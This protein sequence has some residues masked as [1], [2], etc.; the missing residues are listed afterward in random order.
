MCKIGILFLSI[1]FVGC[2]YQNSSESH[3]NVFEGN[4]RGGLADKQLSLTFDDGP[5]A[6]TSGVLDTLAKYNIKATFFVNGNNATRYENLLKRMKSEGHLV[7]NHTY[8][9]PSLPKQSESEIISQIT[10][11]HEAI[12]PY[13]DN[14]A[15]FFRA[16]FG[17]WATWIAN[18]LN[19]AGFDFYVGN[20]FWDIG[21]VLTENYAADWNCWSKSLS[22][23]E[24]G[25]RYIN[26]IKDRRSGI[27]LMHD[28]TSQT[29]R[30]VQY[31]IPKLVEQ[32]Y[33]MTRLDKIAKYEAKLKNKL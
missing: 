27:V 6:H 4:L 15:Y 18:L 5:S 16:P 11:T 33:R 7:A 1:L 9:H 22:P 26:E 3:L 2:S 30:M 29:S 28:V 19:R 25:V 14:D 32:N 17:A 10:R 8:S 12:S 23:Y 20:I 24:C 31:L 13:V 21:G